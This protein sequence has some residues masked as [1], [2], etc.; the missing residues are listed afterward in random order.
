MMKQATVEKTLRDENDTSSA[1]GA[2]ATSRCVSGFISRGKGMQFEYSFDVIGNRQATAAGGNASGSGLR[3]AS[4]AANLLN[5]YTSRTVPGG[6]DVL[7]AAS[8]TNSVTVSGSPADYRRGEFFQE[9]L[10]ANN[11]NAALWQSV[12]VTNTASGA[13][14]TG[15]VFLA[16]SPEAF[17]YDA[18]GNLLSDGRWD[19]TW[20]GGKPAD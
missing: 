16:Q 2:G 7:G 15:A 3:R 9:L 1:L 4:Y 5:Q 8:A 13:Y 12:Q 20:D 6:F 19:S 18:D 10:T 11:T 17:T 14:E